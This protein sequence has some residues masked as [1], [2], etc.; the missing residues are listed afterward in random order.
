MTTRPDA[1]AIIDELRDTLAR[2]FS[3]EMARVLPAAVDILQ[4]QLAAAGREQWKALRGALDLL[5]AKRPTFGAQVAKAVAARFDAKRDPAND[6]L[7]KTARISLDSLSL[8]ADDEVQEEITIGNATRRLREQLGEE[9]FALTQRLAVLMGVETLPDDNRNPAFPRIFA[10]GLFDALGGA[11]ASSAACIA[12]FTAFGPAMLDVIHEVYR[13]ANRKLAERGVLPDFKRSY[14]APTQAA[15]RVASNGASSAYAGAP[16]PAASVTPAANSRHGSVIPASSPLERILATVRGSGGMDPMP[17]PSANPGLV[18][19]EVRP[20]LVEALRGLE[21]RLPPSAGDSATAPMAGEV[22][23]AKLAMGGA[24]NATDSVVADLVAAL[25][26]RLLADR[27]IPDATKAQVSRLQLPVF[28]AV[29]KDPALFAD[30]RHPIRQL[31]DGITELGACDPRAMVDECSPEEWVAA[32][33]Q[34]IVDGADDDPALFTRERDQLAAILVRVN[35]TALEND[36]EVLAL[37]TRERDMVAVREAT[38]AIAHRV[39]AAG[40]SSQAS[41]YLYRC[42]R[43]VMVH[44]Y[45]EGGGDASPDWA[46][47]LE[48]VDDIMWVLVPRTA[49]ADR[50]RLTSLLPS[51][52]YRMRLGYARARLELASTAR[53][54]ELRQLLDGVVRAPLAAAHGLP[55]SAAAVARP[56]ADDYTATLQVSGALRDEGLTRGAW[57]EFRDAGQAPRRCRLTWV[58]PV[59]GACVFKD[60][61]RNRSFPIAIEELRERRRAGTVAMVDGPGIAAA[62]VD[63]ALD[64]VARGLA[65]HD[66]A[67]TSN[68]T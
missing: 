27:R 4:H 61:D 16:G 37:R 54:E 68:T 50:V 30:A 52:L 14:G 6:P 29:M 5:G 41:S 19:I 21:A 40:A 42:W 25:F 22:H 39:A 59:Q 48:V 64:D 38:L 23:R 11:D 18:A 66:R 53:V 67:S 9:L 2:T 44:D 31:I 12:A 24:L 65:V 51:L 47:D 20:E 63:A 43:D 17:K 13:G 35:E 32:A 7:G 28:K 46:L 33:V 26:D 55:L 62:S 15:S 60:L 10:R 56:P 36:P 34:N 45:L 57:V 49:P 58:S 1:P 8:V 3:E